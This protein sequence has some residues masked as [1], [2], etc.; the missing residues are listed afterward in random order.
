M[1]LLLEASQLDPQV[2]KFR[3]ALFR[4]TGDRNMWP[5]NGFQCPVRPLGQFA[6]LAASLAG[7]DQVLSSSAL[8]G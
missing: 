6:D 1:D 8:P 4:T 2:A 3:V 5:C 7:F